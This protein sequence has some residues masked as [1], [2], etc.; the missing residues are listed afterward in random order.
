MM[1][2]KSRAKQPATKGFG[3]V[4]RSPKKR[5]DSHK[6]STYVACL[7]L[8]DKVR[9]LKEKLD[10]LQA[11][12]GGGDIVDVEEEEGNVQFNDNGEE[13]CSFGEGFLIHDSSPI[14][15]EWM[16]E[17]FFPDAPASLPR[18]P[19]SAKDR[20]IGPDA[21]TDLLYDQWKALTPRLIDPLLLFLSTTK[22]TKDTPL[23]GLR[24]CCIQPDLC[25]TKTRK[26]LC[27]FF[28]RAYHS[29]TTDLV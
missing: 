4:Y 25:E 2:S 12:T 29:F 3:R 17:D 15:N 5:R 23:S 18:T 26:V 14:P 7:G 13:A 28:D 21:A 1:L 19:L 10:E 24:S 6:S 27:L 20:R 11:R 16:E 22:G 9:R 8:E